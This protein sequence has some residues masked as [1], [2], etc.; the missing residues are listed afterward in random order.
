[1]STGAECF[2][3][4]TKPAEWHYKLQRWPYGEWPEFDDF[5][6]FKTFGEAQR[7]LDDHHANPG[8]YSVNALPGCKHDLLIA[9]EHDKLYPNECDR[10]GKIIEKGEQ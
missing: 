1:M 5:G 3:E 4:E 8:G 9:R 2:F 7:H 10:C 6:P